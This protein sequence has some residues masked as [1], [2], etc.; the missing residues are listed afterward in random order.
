M[1]IVKTTLFIIAL[2]APVISFAWDGNA[3]VNLKRVIADDKY[4]VMIIEPVQ[5]IPNT[6]CNYGHR[7][8]W[9]IDTPLAEAMY[10]I[11]LTALTTGK[12]VELYTLCRRLC[13]MRVKPT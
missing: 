2:L 5:S 12:K 7:L 9:G 10:S 11:S 6:N 4:A 1:K 3:T 13:Q 8:K